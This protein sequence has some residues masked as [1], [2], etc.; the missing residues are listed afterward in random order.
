MPDHCL[1]MMQMQQKIMST[2]KAQD[3]KIKTL[4]MTMD[5]ATGDRKVQAMAAVINELVTQRASRQEMN[6]KM[7]PQMMG[8]MM[9]HMQSGDKT[10]MMQCPM[11]GSMG[12]GHDMTKMKM[13][14]K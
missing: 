5:K 11:M 9:E 12:M 6:A 2:T 1:M 13:K 7:Q 10:A 8:H 3:S 4:M 14:T